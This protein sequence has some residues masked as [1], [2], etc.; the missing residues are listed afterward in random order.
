MPEWYLL[1]FYAILR[2]V[3]IKLL[4]VCVMFGS[5]LVLFVV[6]WLDTSPVRSSYFR[7][8]Y[9]WVF[10]ILV[11]DCFVLGWVGAHRPEGWFVVIGRI[12]TFYYFLHFLVLLPV[13]GWLEVPLPLPPSISSPVLK[14][15]GGRSAAARQKP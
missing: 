15:G 5:I 7:P 10:W 11:I 2:S 14:K 6:P 1:P 12:G 9:K 3:P 8:V 4:G 13:L